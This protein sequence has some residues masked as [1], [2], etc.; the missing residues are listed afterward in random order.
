MGPYRMARPAAVAAA[1]A[2]MFGACTSG[3]DGGGAKTATTAARTGP[4]PGVTADTIKVGVTYVDTKSLVAAGLHYDLGDHKA[5][6]QALFDDINAHGG[7]DG[8]KIEAVY[9]PINPTSTAPAEEKCVQLTEDDDVFAITGFFLADAVLCPVGTH[10]TAVVGGGMTPERLKQAKAPWITWLPDTD[11]SEAALHRFDDEGLL[12]GKVAVWAAARDKA[13]VDEHIVPTLKALGAAPVA[14]ASAVAPPDDQAAQ[15]TETMTFAEKFKAAG[16]DTVILVGP[17]GQGWPTIMQSDTSYRPKLLFTDV[18]GLTGF[19][20]N[21]ATTDTSVLKGAVAGGGYGPDQARFDEPEMQRCVATLK[22]AGIDTPEP[23]DVGDDPANQPY[24]AAFQACPDVA[25]LRATLAAA[26]KNLN[27][28][29][30]AAAMD[31]LKVTIPGDPTERTY[32][33]P[34]KADGNPSVYLFTWDEGKKALV[35]E[36]G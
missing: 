31:G 13:E 8:R 20:T 6:Y 22:T 14:T 18:I 3:D 34:P 15:R 11:Q 16:A 19:A 26:G 23:K 17:S 1:V 35:R 33:P 36:D 12:D 9:A 24:Q 32:G 4:A 7:I 29:T 30:F 5:V 28:G 2:L 27:Y 10:A 25:L 21:G